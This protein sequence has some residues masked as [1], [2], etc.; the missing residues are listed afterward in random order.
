MYMPNKGNKVAKIEARWKHGI[1]V[2]VR[3]RSNEIMLSTP[4]GIVFARSV[5]RV[6]FKKRWGQDC[7]DWVKWAPLRM[8]KDEEEGDGEVPEGVPAVLK[9]LIDITLSFLGSDSLTKSFVPFV[10]VV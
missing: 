5:R 1:F 8:Y 3:K 7:I 9:H 2:G 4:E 6:P 10:T